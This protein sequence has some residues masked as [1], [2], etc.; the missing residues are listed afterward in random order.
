MSDETRYKN[1]RGILKEEPK[2]RKNMTS[3]RLAS[4]EKSA[5]HGM[6]SSF[7]L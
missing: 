7:E 6:V 4:Q 2:K 5:S 3:S 1:K